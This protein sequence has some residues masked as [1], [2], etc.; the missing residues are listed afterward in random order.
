MSVKFG[1]GSSTSTQ[2]QTDN[3]AQNTAFNQSSTP[4]NPDWVTNL[5]QSVGAGTSALNGTNASTY[6]APANA[7]LT[8]GATTADN[9]SGNPWDYAG[10]LDVST[11]VANAATPSISGDLDSFMSPYVGDVVKSSLADYDHSAG[12]TNAQQALDL[13]GSGAFGGSGAALTQ[14]ATAGELAR[15]RATTASTLLNQGYDTA[16][17][18][19]TS[20]AQLEQQEQA[21]RLAAAGQIAGIASTADATQRAD[22]AAQTAAGAPLQA[23]SQQQA[24]A[25]LDLQAELTQLLSGLPLNLFQGQ[26]QDGTEDQTGTENQTG[27]AT[28]KNSSFGFGSK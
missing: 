5:A 28:G 12:Q 6:V 4:T 7:S 26:N 24:Q 11:G 20:Q 21:Q 16:L 22:S 13:A 27:T 2:Q 1:G 8:Q 23:I 19:A 15:G 14:A 25:P 17:Q 3:S 18:G 9:L 10:A